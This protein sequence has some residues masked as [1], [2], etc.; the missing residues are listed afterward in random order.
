MIRFIEKMQSLLNAITEQNK[1]TTEFLAQDDILKAKESVNHANA[2][3]NE[4]NK[5]MFL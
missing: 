2:L 5:V 1:I 4:F 3:I